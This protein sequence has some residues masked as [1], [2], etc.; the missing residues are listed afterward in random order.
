MPQA[1]AEIA[2]FYGIDASSRLERERRALLG[3]YMT[4]TYVG[5]F[6]AGLFTDLSGH[7]SILDPGAGTGSLTAALVER[8]CAIVE[9]PLSVHLLC[10]EIEPLLIE[11]LCRT[12]EQAVAE[13]DVASITIDTEVKE[14]DFIL[15]NSTGMQTDFFGYGE[16][17]L[18][19]ITHVI[20][21]PPYRKIS[22]LS[23]HRVALRKAGIETS[24][25]YT[26]F[27]FL[28]A[29]Q[30]R[31]GGEMVAIVPRSFCNGPYFK[32]FRK[33]FFADMGL[34]QIH[35]FEKR[36][37]TFRGDDVLQ[38]NIILHAVKGCKPASVKISS[39]AGDMF[40]FD[41]DSGEYV[42]EEMTQRVVE[43]ASVIQPSD[44]DCFVHI[45]TDGLEQVIADRMMRFTV[46]LS[47]IGME[48][49][50]GPIVDFRM[51]NELRAWPE[52]GA[53]PLLYPAHF[54][55]GELEWPRSMKKPN[56]I[57][58]NDQTRKMLWT[59]EGHFV[60]TKR[61]TSKEQR[62]RIVAAVCPSDIPGE[63]LGFENHL[64]VYHVQRKGLSLPLATGLAAYLNS[65]M[66][67]RY[68]RQFSGHT[69]VNATDL[70]L[71]RYPARDE[72][73]RIGS[74][75]GRAPI[76]Q[77]QIDDI[78]GEELAYVMEDDSLALAQQK[79]N[80]ALEILRAMGM[81]R[82]QLNER[83]ALT[84]LALLDLR[85]AGNWNELR[86]PLM[87]ITPIMEF[88]RQQYGREYAPNTRETFRRQTMHQFVEAGV[89]LYN[90]DDP[91]RPVNSPLACYQVS[92]ETF[93]MIQ[94]HGTD[95][96]QRAIVDYLEQIG[97]LAAK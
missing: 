69:Q 21:N 14:K 27:L 67:D 74:R 17:H 20:V 37:S 25:F 75:V 9:K 49:S 89:A 29:Q 68:F 34:K 19:S 7:L 48:V 42:A 23:D 91:N 66:V 40:E 15:S 80:D 64:N 61:F 55:R 1:F 73:E 18:N 12:L 45:A 59:N 72:L 97:S 70:R 54:R 94:A 47:D 24:N 82:G 76:L 95:R 32:H 84:L 96:W 6:M 13:C 86:R 52:P 78:I 10:Y 51:K 38:E 90:P 2:E 8:I 65:S 41:P 88:A 30:L 28:A 43:Y 31:K 16:T 63:L 77:G 35:I 46:T 3:Q 93:R 36:N 22:S 79:I 58:V 92:E 26:G 44:P 81:P 56:A 33:V 83:S 4:P 71:L 85:P 11:Y 87:G 39:S 5:R 53:A 50:T 57:R 60:V 62:R